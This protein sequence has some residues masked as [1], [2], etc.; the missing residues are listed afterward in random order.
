MRYYYYT[1]KAS[2]IYNLARIFVVLFFVLILAFSFIIEPIW[3]NS[4]ER[5][6]TATVTDKHPS[7]D[8]GE[9]LIFCKDSSGETLVFRN[10]DSLIKGKFNSSDFYGQ[11]EIG[12]TYNFTI[13]GSRV[14]FLSMY[15]N[16]ISFTKIHEAID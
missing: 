2:K 15:P 12:K 8:S 16:I 11:I 3:E 7:P 9:Y 10:E 14:P 5:E 13:V 1:Q 4:N 6:I